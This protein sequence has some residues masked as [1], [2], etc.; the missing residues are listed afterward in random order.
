MEI[1]SFVVNELQQVH[2]AVVGLGLLKDRAIRQMTVTPLD[3]LLK[4]VVRNI[5]GTAPIRQIYICLRC[6]LFLA[7]FPRVK[8]CW[9]DIGTGR[10]N[11]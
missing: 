2:A 6:A 10:L 7:F 11:I 1:S 9:T 8:H 3:S 5:I 4:I